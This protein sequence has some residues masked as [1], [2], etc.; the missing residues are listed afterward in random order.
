ML[1][2][3]Q[4]QAS[5]LRA[6]SRYRR[7]FQPAAPQT[8]TGVVSS[9]RQPGTGAVPSL[10]GIAG[11]P[12][13]SRKT[14]ARSQPDQSRR[15]RTLPDA[16]R[17]AA[18]RMTLTAAPAEAGQRRRAATPGFDSVRIAAL[19]LAVR[20]QRRGA[21][22]ALSSCSWAWRSCS[23]SQPNTRIAGQRRASS[24]V[25]GR[26]GWLASVGAQHNP[27]PYALAP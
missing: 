2:R 13:S 15:L 3:R 11:H 23:N 26:G 22:S 20:R 19:R 5:R 24:G 8:S 17:H 9:R 10:A 7:G 14:V 18:R 27:V 21:P 16:C 1:I 4:L 25:A 6:G 12:T